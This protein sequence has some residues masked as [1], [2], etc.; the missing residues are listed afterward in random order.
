MSREDLI[1]R[2]EEVSANIENVPL[3]EVATLLRRAAIRL[4]NLPPI[5]DETER[6]FRAL[7]DDM[8]NPDQ[9]A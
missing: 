2:L 4:R 5:D 1:L 6:E 7:M 3:N 8:M 9:P